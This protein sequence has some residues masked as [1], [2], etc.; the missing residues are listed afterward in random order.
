MRQ[1]ENSLRT[2]SEPTGQHRFRLGAAPSRPLNTPADVFI[3]IDMQGFP[4]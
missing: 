4:E 2:P 3:G 1:A